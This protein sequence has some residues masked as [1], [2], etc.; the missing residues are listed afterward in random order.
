[1]PDVASVAVGQWIPEDWSSSP[2]VELY[3]NKS[4]AIQIAT[5]DG[6]R[7]EPMSTR[8]KHVPKDTGF[9]VQF[10]AKGA[11]YG[12]DA[13]PGAQILL[14]AH[15]LTGAAQFDD[16]DIQ[17]AANFVNVFLTKQRSG[18]SNLALL[19]D[20]AVFGV[21]G[22]ATAEPTMTRPY[23]SLPQA[24]L[25][26][27]Q[28]DQFSTFSRAGT[29]DQQRA[30]V[31]TALAYAETSPWSSDDLV[32]VASPA[33]KQFMRNAPMNGFVGVPMWDETAG[34]VFGRPVYWTRGAVLTTA[35]S[36][37]PGV[38]NPLLYF[39]PRAHLVFGRRLDLEWMYTDPRIG[40]GAL[41]DTA[42]LKVRQRTAYQ[43]GDGAAGA[44]VQMV[45]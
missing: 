32:C 10:T 16:E 36:F 6:G 26:S 2:L 37:A 7:F 31:N 15:K 20:N 34:T 29:L 28:A 42:Y 38:A 19:L 24:I 23:E 3:K 43:T 18:V 5:S 40:I 1:V 9:D 25:T 41:S 8:L 45:A 39:V 22:A 4:A 12:L 11:T 33:F 13:Q 35:A 44:M 14:Q 17:D 30:A 21:T 27:N